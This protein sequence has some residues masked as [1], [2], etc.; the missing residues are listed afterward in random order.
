[1]ANDKIFIVDC[2]DRFNN[3]VEHYIQITERHKVDMNGCKFR[4]ALRIDNS[5][6]S[7]NCSALFDVA[8]MRWY[9]SKYYV[10]YII[11]QPIINS[12]Y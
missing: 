9:V 5:G 2:N 10:L 8:G 12:I 7:V 11:R 4:R 3:M 1:M 6:W